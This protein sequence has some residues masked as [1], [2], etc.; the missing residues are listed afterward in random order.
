MPFSELS[1]HFTAA[2]IRRTLFLNY[3]GEFEQAFIL[4]KVASNDVS[5]H[6]SNYTFV[7]Y[8]DHH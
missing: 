5:F 7:V 3:F 2:K 1:S 4:A 8:F 6:I